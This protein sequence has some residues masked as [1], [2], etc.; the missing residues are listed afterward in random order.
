M[1]AP[2]STSLSSFLRGRAGVVRELLDITGHLDSCAVVLHH[3]ERT[4]SHALLTHGVAGAAGGMS[5]AKSLAVE[6]ARDILTVP[7]AF[8]VRGDTILLSS[9]E[10][11]HFRVQKRGWATSKGGGEE[12][13]EGTGAWAWANIVS[14]MTALVAVSPIAASQVLKEGI[15]KQ[16]LLEYWMVVIGR[17][18]PTLQDVFS[19]MWTIW[20]L[21]SSTGSRSNM[22]RLVWCLQHN[23]HPCVP[24][25]WVAW[26]SARL[27]DP[28]VV[29]HHQHTLV[30][31]RSD[32]ASPIATSTPNRQA[33]KAVTCLARPKLH[34]YCS[35]RARVALGMHLHGGSG[36]MRGSTTTLENMYG[37]AQTV[38]WDTLAQR[39]GMFRKWTTS[40]MDVVLFRH[41][42]E[43]MGAWAWIDT[44]DPSFQL[45]SLGK[46]TQGSEGDGESDDEEQAMTASVVLS[47][48]FA[49]LRLALWN[50]GGFGSTCHPGD[51]VREW[52]HMA[53]GLSLYGIA[54]VDGSHSPL[55]PKHWTPRLVVSMVVDNDDIPSLS[56]P[57][58]QRLEQPVEWNVLRPA[59]N[60][61]PHDEVWGGWSAHEW[62]AYLH[63]MWPA[64]FRSPATH[65][66][67]VFVCSRARALA[68][69]TG[70]MATSTFLDRALGL[71]PETWSCCSI[72]L[73]DGG[74]CTDRAVM[75][76]HAP[77]LAWNVFRTCSWVSALLLPPN[78]G[79]QTHH[80]PLQPCVLGCMDDCSLGFTLCLLWASMT[81]ALRTPLD[82]WGPLSPF[83]IEQTRLPSWGATFRRMLPALVCIAGHQPRETLFRVLGC[84]VCGRSTRRFPIAVL[85]RVLASTSEGWVQGPRKDKQTW[86]STLVPVSELRHMA[87]RSWE[88]GMVLL[89]PR[90]MDTLLLCIALQNQVHQVDALLHLQFPKTFP[91][92]CSPSPPVSKEGW[93]SSVDND[94]RERERERECAQKCGSGVGATS[95]RWTA[96]PSLDAIQ[97]VRTVLYGKEEFSSPPTPSRVLRPLTVAVSRHETGLFAASMATSL[98]YLHWS[99]HTHPGACAQDRVLFAPFASPDVAFVSLK[100]VWFGVAKAL[101]KAP[102]QL[103]TKH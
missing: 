20:H 19:V 53:A 4:I 77:T 99:P 35:Q 94:E 69:K 98:P 8:N 22:A 41:A 89:P 43:D 14:W 28:V 74:L 48:T 7:Y 100:D 64:Q 47:R 87:N 51:V 10:G 96:P 5:L 101:A 61:L 29:G 44:P 38:R 95:L 52:V 60:L 66:S 85:K 11:S 45:P 102:T 57:V 6:V 84:V 82:A 73:S 26:V 25:A 91:W 36:W 97:F 54:E 80:F 70:I 90:H 40:Q 86:A 18:L 76:V 65:T 50:E 30:R 15:H 58:F 59:A 56:D 78:R 72:P 13:G 79:G 62:G 88:D 49:V 21:C 39:L 9:R 23:T 63:G 12:G 81:T 17:L 33:V 46:H 31:V 71:H 75:V 32:T 3:A 67:T 42:H 24:R 1:K 34:A 2:S 83:R 103:T 16:R 68:W 93:C 55:Q 92:V 27:L 37:R